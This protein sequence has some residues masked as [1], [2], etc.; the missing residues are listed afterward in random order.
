LDIIEIELA[1]NKE[2]RMKKFLVI[3]FFLFFTITSVFAADEKKD[4]NVE[5]LKKVAHIFAPKTAESWMR[6]DLVVFSES[7]KNELK[8]LNKDPFWKNAS[9]AEKIKK[10][11][12]NNFFC[13]E[14]EKCLAN[15]NKDC[16]EPL[17][18]AIK[19]LRI[20]TITLYL[21]R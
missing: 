13:I 14:I 1:A 10:R 9:E 8:G 7:L 17:A 19:I 21:D 6:Q 5:D 11:D 20:K 16:Y 18:M 3:M 2:E 15:F 12:V 4:K